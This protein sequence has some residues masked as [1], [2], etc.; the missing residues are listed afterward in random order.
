MSGSHWPEATS[1]L[2]L[3]RPSTRG[4]GG[5]GGRRIASSISGSRRVSRDKRFGNL[6]MAIAMNMLMMHTLISGIIRFRQSLMTMMAIM[7]V[8]PVL[9]MIAFTCLL[10]GQR[11]QG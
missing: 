2:T 5:H 3:S 1:G 8:M 7:R 6:I 11:R 10:W 4:H 9:L